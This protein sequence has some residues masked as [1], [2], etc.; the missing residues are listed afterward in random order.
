M[1][2]FDNV[3]SNAII[4]INEYSEPIRYST[5]D[6]IGYFSLGS[7]VVLVFEYDKNASV[8][9]KPGQHL[10]LGEPLLVRQNDFVGNKSKIPK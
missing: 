2:E 6:E 8:M 5:G 3:N 7:T 1:K 10:I 4:D 9:V